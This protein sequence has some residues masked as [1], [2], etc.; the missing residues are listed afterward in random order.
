V[1]QCAN[2]VEA[3]AEISVGYDLLVLAG[4]EKPS[5]WAQ[6]KTPR[7]DRLTNAAACSVLQLKTPK[8][9]S[10]NFWQI[11]RKASIPSVDILSYIHPACIKV[12]N[13]VS[14]KE[15]LF[16][17][18]AEVFAEGIK[19]LDKQTIE[20]GLWARERSYNTAVGMHVGM[21][22]VTLPGISRPYLGIFTTS[23]SVDYQS[24]DGELADVFFV[25]LSPPEE[26]EKHL[27][28]LAE[29][30]NLIQ[31][32]H[33]LEQLRNAKDTQAVMLACQQCESD[34]HPG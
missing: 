16:S 24:L 7:V 23:N 26:R 28:L 21:P 27:L 3:L 17:Q 30:A 18:I 25:T 29:I 13:N 6:F 20:D 12:G 14:S 2:D 11:R 4:Q 9:L 8:A 31:Q 32:T 10:Q 34:L 33:F 1:I 22:H 15:E 19:D 5:L